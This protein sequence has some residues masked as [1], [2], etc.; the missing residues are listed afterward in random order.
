VE[1]R[2]IRTQWQYDFL[3]ERM[4]QLKGADPYT[5]EGQELK[6]LTEM[7]VEY[8]LRMAASDDSPSEPEPASQTWLKAHPGLMRN[9]QYIIRNA[10]PPYPSVIAPPRESPLLNITLVIKQTAP[11]SQFGGWGFGTLAGGIT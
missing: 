8:E 2:L 11:A 5:P 6:V 4:E 9:T 1:F 7:A 3:A 10:H